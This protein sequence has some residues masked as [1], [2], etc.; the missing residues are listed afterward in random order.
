MWHNFPNT[1]GGNGSYDAKQTKHTDDIATRLKWRSGQMECHARPDGHHA[2]ETHGWTEGVEPDAWLGYE[3]PASL[4]IK[5]RYVIEE[6]ML[7]A[8]YWD[9]DGD[10]A[11]GD[12]SRT[13]AAEILGYGMPVAE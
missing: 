2:G 5:C 6:G 7:G 8:M 3:D 4:T 13:V 10:T 1:T 12:L 9:Y 11:E